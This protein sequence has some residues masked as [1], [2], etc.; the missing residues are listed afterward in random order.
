MW[1][2]SCLFCT[3]SLQSWKKPPSGRVSGGSPSAIKRAT[4]YLLTYTKQEVKVFPSSQA[5]SLRLHPLCRNTIDEA[6]P[7]Y[8][9]CFLKFTFLFFFLWIKKF[10]KCFAAFGH[11]RPHWSALSPS[12]FVRVI[13]CKRN[14]VR[15]TVYLN[16]SLYIKGKYPGWSQ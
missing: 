1:K 3:L 12:V 7:S 8:V 11:R 4:T 2:F 10:C 6:T 14:I 9:H 15:V 13:E 16:R 5:Q